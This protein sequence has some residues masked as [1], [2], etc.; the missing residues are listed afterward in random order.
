LV[1]PIPHKSSEA[2]S[3]ASSTSG[4]SDDSSVAPKGLDSSASFEVISGAPTLESSVVSPF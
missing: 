2:S 3:F 1:S 4:S